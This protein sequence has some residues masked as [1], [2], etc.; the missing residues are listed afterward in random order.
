MINQ[1]IRTHTEYSDKYGTDITNI[2][3]TDFEKVSKIYIILKL[4]LKPKL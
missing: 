4:K 3:K 1:L 2:I